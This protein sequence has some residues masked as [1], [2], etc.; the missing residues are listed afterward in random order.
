MYAAKK[1]ASTRYSLIKGEKIVR[2]LLTT[3]LREFN[4]FG[5]APYNYESPIICF[6]FFTMWDEV[7][8]R[9]N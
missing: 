2:L 3:R 1:V 6:I 7:I 5:R 9:I 4:H 8:F